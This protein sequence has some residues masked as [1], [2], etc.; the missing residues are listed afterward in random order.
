M[1]MDPRDEM[2]CVRVEEGHVEGE[3]G[4]LLLREKACHR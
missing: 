1:R 3:V 2:P 4:V